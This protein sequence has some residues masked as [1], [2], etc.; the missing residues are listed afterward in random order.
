MKT[1]PKVF[2]FSAQRP[3]FFA[4][5]VVF[6]VLLNNIYPRAIMEL[7]NYDV[8]VLA[9]GSQSVFL[10]LFDL[11]SQV[12][13]ELANLLFNNKTQTLGNKATRNHKPKA[14]TNSSSDF[15]IL[16]FEARQVQKVLELGSAFTGSLGVLFA[17]RSLPECMK[18]MRLN[19]QQGIF[20]FMFLML[21]FSRPRGDTPDIEI[22]Q[23]TNIFNNIK[24]G[25]NQKP[26]FLFIAPSG[27]ISEVFL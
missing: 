6:C 19:Y 20:Y 10:H 2:S 5:M 25:L 16:S 17:G 13:I 1:I 18:T 24:L 21:F 12:S 14:A 11:P 27:Q 7:K 22:K 4:L 15:S 23:T 8:V 3:R 26:G 9:M